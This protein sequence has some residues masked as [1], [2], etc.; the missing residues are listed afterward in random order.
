MNRAGAIA[1]GLYCNRVL[2]DA[3]VVVGAEASSRQDRDSGLAA[4]HTMFE[5]AGSCKMD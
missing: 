2:A 3:A 4:M 5:T 1:T